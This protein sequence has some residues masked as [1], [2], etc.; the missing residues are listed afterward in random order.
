MM[1]DHIITVA[2]DL[3]GDGEVAGIDSTGGYALYYASRA[4][5]PNAGLDANGNLWLCFSAYTENVDNGMLIS[6]AV[7]LFHDAKQNKTDGIK[8]IWDNKWVHLRSS[9]TEPIIRIISEA[10]T[11]KEAKD[12]IIKVKSL[13]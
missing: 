10:T 13:L 4:S 8:F 6:K 11:E 9:N 7:N 12:L 1:N 5:M 3:N 2:P